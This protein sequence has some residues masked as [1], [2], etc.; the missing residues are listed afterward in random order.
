MCIE[1]G[2]KHLFVNFVFFKINFYKILKKTP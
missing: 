1:V 2:F